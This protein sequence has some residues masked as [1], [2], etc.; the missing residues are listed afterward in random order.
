M[1]TMER[2]LLRMGNNR[3][4]VFWLGLV[5]GLA[6]AGAVS[7]LVI[8]ENAYPAVYLRYALGS[9][10]ILYLPGEVLIRCLF[11][12]RELGEVERAALD[13][14]TSMVVVAIMALIL[15]FTPWGIKLLPITLALS[16]FIS[17]FALLTII[18]K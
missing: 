3:S 2:R 16:I 13:V 10:L 1:I 17:F 8:D 9:L 7:A 5:I 14:V 11:P 18:R 6:A 15:N 12:Q 4:G